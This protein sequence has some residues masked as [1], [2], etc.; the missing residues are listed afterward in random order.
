[1]KYAVF[2]LG[3]RTY[4]KFNEMA[5]VIDERMEE[6]G[7]QRIFRTGLGDDDQ[8]IESDFL[9]WKK[10]FAQAVCKGTIALLSV[11]STV[12]VIMTLLFFHT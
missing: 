4:D 12:I 8:N 2:G 11:K 5:K 7:A 3:N 1:M 9:V 10:G 6:L